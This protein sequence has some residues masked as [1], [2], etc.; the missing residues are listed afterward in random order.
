MNKQILFI[1]SFFILAA[2]SDNN[3]P[4]EDVFKIT[5]IGELSTTE[6]TVGKIIKLDDVGEEWYE[7]GDRKLLISCKAKVKAGIDLTKIGENDIKVSG[8]TIEITLPPAEITSFSMDPN[9]IRTEM[10][11]VSGLRL[12]FSQEE[13]ND[14]LKQGEDAIKEDL[15]ETGILND[16]TDNAETFL[17]D[18]YKQMGYEKIIVNKSEPNE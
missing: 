11:S 3:G 7:Y 13:K 17:I 8:S 4:E 2:C 6:Y 5:N 1:I 9:L 12:S 16:A 15:G 14:I 18:F 10:E